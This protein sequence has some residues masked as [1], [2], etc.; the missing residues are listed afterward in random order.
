MASRCPCGC[1]TKTGFLK[2][3]ASVGW[4]SI[5]GPLLQLRQ[6][7]DGVRRSDVS[8]ELAQMVD[9]L[10]RRGQNLLALLELHLHS[11]NPLN[12]EPNLMLLD[13]Q[14]KEWLGAV[15]AM[16]RIARQLTP[17]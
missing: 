7:S 13:A 15:A 16:D 8:S 2:R 14:R 5:N 9:G 17:D 6:I 10:I 3:G 1:G 12:V 4:S 11:P